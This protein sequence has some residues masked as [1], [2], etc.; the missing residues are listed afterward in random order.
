MVYFTVGNIYSKGMKY[1]ERTQSMS[2]EDLEIVHQAMKTDLKKQIEK[3]WYAE[4]RNIYTPNPFLF[5][6]HD[7]VY[8]KEVSKKLCYMLEPIQ[9]AR[10]TAVLRFNIKDTKDIYPSMI[11]TSEAEILAVESAK[12][13]I[14]KL[15]FIAHNFKFIKKILED[16]K[17]DE[18]LDQKQ[19]NLYWEQYQSVLAKDEKEL[20]AQEDDYPFALV[21]M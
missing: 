18:E 21:F 8:W 16:K 19:P 13:V 20:T 6:K 12:K 9:V 3:R 7:V 4:A 17:A 14:T 5:D 15:A 2:M 10:D 11:E 1:F